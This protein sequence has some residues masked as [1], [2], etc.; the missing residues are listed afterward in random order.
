MP[1]P[2]KTKFRRKDTKD[3]E[4]SCR[5]TKDMA[6]EMDMRTIFIGTFPISFKCST[7]SLTLLDFFK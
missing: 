3:D 4:S 7:L 5:S 6:E 2:K 1:T